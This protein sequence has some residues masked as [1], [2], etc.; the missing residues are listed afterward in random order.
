MR[1]CTY[2]LVWSQSWPSDEYPLSAIIPHFRT[3][4]DCTDSSRKCTAKAVLE[5]MVNYTRTLPYSINVCYIQLLSDYYIGF[6]NFILNLVNWPRGWS[7]MWHESSTL[8]FHSRLVFYYNVLYPYIV[9]YIL[10]KNN[11]FLTKETHLWNS[12]VNCKIIALLTSSSLMIMNM[13]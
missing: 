1:S 5:D 6:R 13:L 2:L 10:S 12:V 9:H 8:C 7:T 3:H 4:M 11:R